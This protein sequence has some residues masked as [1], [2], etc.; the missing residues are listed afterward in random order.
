[1]D[2]KEMH[3]DRLVMIKAGATPSGEMSGHRRRGT[4]RAEPRSMLIPSGLV[5]AVLKSAS[6]PPR[7]SMDLRDLQVVVNLCYANKKFLRRRIISNLSD[8]LGVTRC[9]SLTGVGD[10]DGQEEGEIDIV[11]DT[12]AETG[13]LIDCGIGV[14]KADRVNK[15]G[16]VAESGIGA[17]SSPFED[18]KGRG[19]FELCAR[20]VFMGNYEELVP[21]YPDL[22][23]G[24]IGSGKM[25]RQYEILKVISKDACRKS[26]EQ[27]SKDSKLDIREGSS[28]YRRL[29]AYIRRSTS[30]TEDKQ[31]LPANCVFW[32]K[33]DIHD[34]AKYEFRPAAVQCVALIATIGKAGEKLCGLGNDD[35]DDYEPGT[36]EPL[37]GKA[38][39]PDEALD[40]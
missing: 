30:A 22:S 11:S 7:R 2:K 9:D 19:T 28:K 24:V 35:A 5:S 6:T 17:P 38:T 10:L 32:R 34:A 1:M 23:K 4:P 31:C 27:P 13:T 3:E 18:K 20:R 14:I 37:E 15:S 39:D 16:P 12:D 8:A 21:D 33:A 36:A 40:G 25:P 29:A 26:H